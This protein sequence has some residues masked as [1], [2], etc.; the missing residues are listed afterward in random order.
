[1]KLLRNICIALMLCVPAFAWNCP[2]GQIRQQAPAGT[3]TTTPYYDVVEGIAFICVP[4]TPTPNPS[5]ASNTNT[6]TNSN[7]NTNNVNNT[8]TNKIQN[9]VSNQQSQKQQQQQQQNQSQ[10]ATGG[11]ATSNRSEERRV[12]QEGRSR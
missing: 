3:P 1:M 11:N 2:A 12:R 8:L 7:S 6:N 10:V 5:T 4:S 9:T